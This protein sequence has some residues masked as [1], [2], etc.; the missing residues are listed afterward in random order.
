[1]A[2]AAMLQSMEPAS[3]DC[4]RPARLCRASDSLDFNKGM[5]QL[6]RERTEQVTAVYPVADL[7]RLLEGRGGGANA[8]GTDR[9]RGSPELVRC[10][11]QGRKVP[12]ARGGVN[13]PFR[14]DRGLTEFPQQRIDGGAIVAEPSRKD[15]AVDCGGGFRLGR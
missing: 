12:V 15:V 11:G 3:D 6:H 8:D 7:A 9:L 14:L 2:K 10:H 4:I 13:L 5:A 1:M